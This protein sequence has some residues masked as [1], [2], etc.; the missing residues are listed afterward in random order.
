MKRDMYKT[1]EMAKGIITD[2]YDLTAPEVMELYR[3]AHESSGGVLDAI[4]TAFLYGFMLGH[5][6]TNAGKCGK[7]SRK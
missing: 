7:T 2:R 3:K 1:A 6:A 4:C 5:R